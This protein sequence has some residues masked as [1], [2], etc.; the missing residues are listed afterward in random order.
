MLNPDFNPAPHGC[1]HPPQLHCE[2]LIDRERSCGLEI[3]DR[4]SE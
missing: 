3:C 1:S 2:I 4:R